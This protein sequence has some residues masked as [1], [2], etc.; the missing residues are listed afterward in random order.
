VTAFTPDYG[1]VRRVNNLAVGDWISRQNGDLNFDGHV[2]LHDAFI[3]HEGLVGAGF[4]AGLDFGLLTGQIPEPTAAAH[5]AV[6]LLL[7]FGG[8]RLKAIRRD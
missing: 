7:F 3:L 2:D 1:S 5:V 4:A 8:R 6:F